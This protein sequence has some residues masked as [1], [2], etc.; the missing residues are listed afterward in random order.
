[1]TGE[2][3]L[4]LNRIY[5]VLTEKLSN[6]NDVTMDEIEESFREAALNCGKIALSKFLTEMSEETPACPSCGKNMKNHGKRDK[7]IVTLLGNCEYSRNYYNCE[8]GE[9]AIPKD[10]MLNVSGTKFTQVVK[11]VTSQIAASDSFR[12]TSANLKYLCGI[13][14][15]AKEA[16]R[17]AEDAGAEII[18]AKQNEIEYSLT[19]LNPTEPET[20]ANIMYIEYDGTGVPIR[21]QELAGV[22]GKQLDGSA[23]SREMK[24]GCI[25]TQSGLND[26][27]KPVR[28]ADS[29]TYFS[30]IGQLED[31]GKLLYSEAVKRGVDYAGQVVVI[32]DGAKWIWGLASDNFPNATQIIDLYHAKEHVF[33]VLRT[34]ISN[35]AELCAQKRNLYKKLENGD[36]DGLVKCFSEFPINTEEQAEKI[37]IESNYFMQNKERMQYQDFSKKGFFVGS[38]V[39]EAACKNV[40]GKRLKQSGMM[41]SV[42]GANK[43]A[44][45]RCAVMSGEF[46]PKLQITA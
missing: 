40:V 42:A 10:E 27:G 12:D 8:C 46:E 15:S 43:I 34:V 37:R 45:L 35:E 32:G 23:R 4:E 41:W 14:V 31:F 36:I 5:E 28:D 18:A 19:E 13:D 3:T 39:I 38:G 17:I 44:A 29:T 9:Y 16:E 22:K 24:T 21:K 7:Q 2:Y 30:Q 20:P 6:N 26:E 33:D 11:R 25:F 1:M